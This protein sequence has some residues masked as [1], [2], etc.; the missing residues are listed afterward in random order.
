MTYRLTFLAV[1][2]DS[3]PLQRRQPGSHGAPD[4]PIRDDF[5]EDPAGADAYVLAWKIWLQQQADGVLTKAERR[6]RANLYADMFAVPFEIAYNL[7]LRQLQGINSLSPA[8]RRVVLAA[9]DAQLV[10]DVH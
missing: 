1:P 8:D 6:V 5:P 9:L 3:V 7:T 10:P 4:S 2:T